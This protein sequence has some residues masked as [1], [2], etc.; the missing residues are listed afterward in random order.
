MLFQKAAFVLLGL[1]AF[2]EAVSIR[3]EARLLRRQNRGGSN[4]GNNGKGGNTGDQNAAKATD[5]AKATSTAKAA[6]TANNNG[7]NNNTAAATCLN[8]KAIQTGSQSDGQNPPVAGQ[9]ASA[10]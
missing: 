5:A 1:A 6:G 2:T 8:A 4:N 9:S 3:E 10:T 7:G